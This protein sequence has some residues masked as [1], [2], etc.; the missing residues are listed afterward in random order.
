MVI[1]GRKSI[2]FSNGMEVV[3]YHC[4]SCGTETVQTARADG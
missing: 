2:P 4:E 3:A 1:T